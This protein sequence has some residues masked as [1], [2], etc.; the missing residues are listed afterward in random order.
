M[1]Y[2]SFSL[3]VYWVFVDARYLKWFD[4][5]LGPPFGFED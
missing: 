5:V 1:A 4:E 2:L 3:L